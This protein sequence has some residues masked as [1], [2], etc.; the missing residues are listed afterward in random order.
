MAHLT[1]IPVDVRPAAGPQATDELVGHRRAGLIAA[2]GVCTGRG[3]ARTQTGHEGIRC[4]RRRRRAVRGGPG[5]PAT[6]HATRGRRGPR[7]AV[8]APG[9]RRIL[10]GHRRGAGGVGEAARRL[11]AGARGRARSR[12]A[13][14]PRPGGR[15]GRPR[16]V[17][18]ARRVQGIGRQRP[19]RQ[20][21]HL[22]P[23]LPPRGGA[24]RRVPHPHRRRGVRA[25]RPLRQRHQ[26]PPGRAAD[27]AS[28]RVGGRVAGPVG[29]VA[30][31]GRHGAGGRPLAEGRAH[32]ARPLRTDLSRPRSGRR[33]RQLGS[34]P[35]APLSQLRAQP[36]RRLHERAP[37]QRPLPHPPQ[38]AHPP[39]ADVAGAGARRQ[40]DVRRAH[41]ARG[42]HL[43][44][45]PRAQDPR[46]ATGPATTSSTAASAATT[47]WR[48]S[49]TTSC[50]CRISIPTW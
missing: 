1:G 46:T 43:G 8:R 22:H 31:A 5:R 40:H 45:P 12:V 49:C 10:H 41:G 14:P 2:R 17:D 34:V 42:G 27:V 28:R 13:V 19:E 32:R 50:C 21:P 47:S 3:R 9:Q 24:G 29:R 18:G 16:P 36:R 38:G 26:P 7:A 48:T 39:A 25:L 6:R 15:P 33:A 44:L 37:V 30:A 20:R 11:A 4:G 35:R 23:A